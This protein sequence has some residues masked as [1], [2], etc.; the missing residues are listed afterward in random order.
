MDAVQRHVA[1]PEWRCIVLYQAK[2]VW[3]CIRASAM[4]PKRAGKHGR[5]FMV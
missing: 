4:Q 3:Q 1:D 5:Y 2:K